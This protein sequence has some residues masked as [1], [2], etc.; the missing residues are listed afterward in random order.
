VRP[1]LKYAESTEGA[2]SSTPANLRIALVDTRHHTCT[3][4][5]VRAHRLHSVRE[6]PLQV[7]LS[8]VV[9][10]C[11]QWVSQWPVIHARLDPCKRT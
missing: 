2:A 4:G 5:L 11:A 10:A 7:R 8:V 1:P 6:S 3:S 9:S